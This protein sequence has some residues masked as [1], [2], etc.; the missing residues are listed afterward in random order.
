MLHLCTAD[1]P[2]LANQS[3]TFRSGIESAP[4]SLLDHL[5][6]LFSTPKTF[7]LRLPGATDSRCAPVVPS[8]LL[9]SAIT[10]D[11]SQIQAYEL[12]VLFSLLYIQMET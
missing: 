11:D 10:R 12:Q 2:T 5:L 8:A 4:Q 1:S 3:Y 7:S 9:L 6:S